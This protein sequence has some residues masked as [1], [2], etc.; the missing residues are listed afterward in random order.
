VHNRLRIPLLMGLLVAS[1]SGCGAAAPPSRPTRS[2][3]HAPYGR[4]H[5]RQLAPR[6]VGPTA[7]LS[8]TGGANRAC[9]A[10][11]VGVQIATDRRSYQP[12][13]LVMFVVTARNDA[14]SS[15]RVPTGP[16]L[17][18]VAVTAND[19]VVV[20]NRAE[21]QVA[22]EFHGSRRLG[23][24]AATREVVSWDG[25]RCAGRTPS[26]CPGGPVSP[27]PY[28]AMARWESSRSASTRFV[29]HR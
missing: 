16:C 22:C 1:V 23:P 2:E 9:S 5:T 26:S 13:R 27:G 28:L 18:Q 8:P 7:A 19:G 6:D 29:I 21:L 10:A 15:C 24:G 17:P 14:R 25:S 11:K 4:I 20:W 12:A 3:P